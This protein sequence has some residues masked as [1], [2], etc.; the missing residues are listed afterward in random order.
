MKK[1]K[2][3]R[4]I[5]LDEPPH[6]QEGREAFGNFARLVSGIV[7]PTIKATRQEMPPPEE[8]VEVVSTIMVGIESKVMFET[9]EPGVC[10]PFYQ[11][12]DPLSGIERQMV[13]SAFKTLMTMR[14]LN[15]K[16]FAEMMM[17]IYPSPLSRREAIREILRR[18]RPD[19]SNDRREVWRAELEKAFES[20]P[21]YGIEVLTKMKT[22]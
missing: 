21:A 22:S 2:T 5:T 10:T 7:Q 8:I 4:C 1:Q 15:R 19:E 17:K 14:R 3:Q 9:D 11:L 6:Q 16:R 20:E 18:D 12:S 13:A